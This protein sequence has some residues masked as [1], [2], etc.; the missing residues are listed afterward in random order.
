MRS[1]NS[2]SEQSLCGLDEYIAIEQ[3]IVGCDCELHVS[4][5]NNYENH[6]PKLEMRFLLY[7]GTF[8]F[9][10]LTKIHPSEDK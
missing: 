2:F 3:W 7:V 10:S 5:N 9:G 4:L 1:I 6:I 8:E